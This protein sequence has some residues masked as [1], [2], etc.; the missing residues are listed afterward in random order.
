[1]RK[2]TTATLASQARGA[3]VRFIL[4]KYAAEFLAVHDAE[5]DKRG[6]RPLDEDALRKENE[7]LRARIAELEKTAS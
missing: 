2:P 7:R 5:R 6:L 4:T 3:A 1:M